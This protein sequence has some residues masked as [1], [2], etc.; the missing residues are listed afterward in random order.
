MS[1]ARELALATALLLA[2]VAGP[3]VAGPGSNLPSPPPG[4]P[5]VLHLGLAD[6]P[7]GAAALRATSRLGFRY[8]YLSGGLGNGWARWGNGQFV[9][10]YI[11]ESVL[12]EFTPVFSYYMLLQSGSGGGSEGDIVAANLQ[13][14]GLMAGYFD[15]LRRFF[16]QAA[17]FP[18]SPVV[19]HVEPDLWGYLHQRG[20]DDGAGIPV[21][22]GAT[23]LPDLAGLPDTLS[24]FARA[25]G[26]LRDR[27]A[28]HVRL[29][30]HLSVWGTRADF[31]SA[32]S[33]DAEVDHLATRAAAFFRSIGG[34]FE[35]VF[36]EFSDRDAGFK[37]LVDPGDG[38]ASWWDAEDFRRHVR[39]LATF[40]GVAGKRVVL[41]QIPLGNTRMLAMNNTWNHYQ[42][43]RVEWLLDDPGR[44]H[45]QAYVEAGVIGFLFGRGADGATCACD[46]SGDGVTNPGPIGSNT[47]SSLSADDDGIFRQKAGEYYA[48]GALLLAP[49][50]GAIFSDVPLDHWARHWI[51]TLHG[52]GVT[53]CGT[54]PARYCPDAAVTR[55]EMAV[56]LLRA[57]EG[58]AFAPP[59][60]GT[61]PFADVPCADGFAAWIAE[62]ARR[63]VAAGC[64]AGRY[65]SDRPVSRQEMAVLLLKVLEG[66]A[67][68]PD[69]HD[70]DVRRR[71]LRQPVRGVGVRA[72]AA[73]HHERLRLRPILPG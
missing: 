57:E 71:A 58:V 14:A 59:T 44:G 72:G 54:A 16:E 50:P 52:R 18:G 60:C 28:P 23:G 33:S 17:A 35:L 67:Y 56:F 40:V 39:F 8:Q 69:V 1:A 68:Q 63:G 19:L 4:W 32:N 47:G 66:P 6:S 62:L 43:N 27:Y 30:Y 49:P 25:L 3:A 11:S 64:G 61:P 26:V 21:K 53:G 2:L 36:G 41:W 73:G 20:G 37:Q 51:E 45:L 34:P 9:R 42:D 65:C 38:G 10:D 22:V 13:N 70:P 7:G 31:A 5:D 48:A 46:A 55:A 15:D 12:H 29:A 24:G